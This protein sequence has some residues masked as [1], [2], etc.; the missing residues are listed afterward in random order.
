V[1]HVLRRLGPGR[2]LRL[3]GGAGLCRRPGPVQAGRELQRSGQLPRHQR[4]RP[5]RRLRRSGGIRVRA[6]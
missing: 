4:H 3:R 6:L 5:G 1:L 2:P